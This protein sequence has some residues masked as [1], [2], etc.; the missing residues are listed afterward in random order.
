MDLKRKILLTEE[1]FCD[2]ENARSHKPRPPIP[3]QGGGCL[4]TQVGIPTS[5][6]LT[7]TFIPVQN[8]S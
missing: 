2:K 8:Q 6:S 1:E 4:E 5:E 7:L 3:M